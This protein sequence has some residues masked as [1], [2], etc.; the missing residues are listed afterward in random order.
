VFGARLP[1]HRQRLLHAFHLVSARRRRGSVEQLAQH[2]A[3]A[4]AWPRVW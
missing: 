1:Q 3:A 4:L 2:V